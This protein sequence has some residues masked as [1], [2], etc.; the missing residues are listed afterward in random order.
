MN[1][2]II[3]I[4]NFNAQ[5]EQARKKLAQE[6]TAALSYL[7]TNKIRGKFVIEHQIGRMTPRSFP[8]SYDRSLFKIYTYEDGQLSMIEYLGY[9]HLNER[10]R[11]KGAK[12]REIKPEEVPFAELPLEQL[13]NVATQIKGIEDSSH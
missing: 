8:P 2:R 11:I 3:N 10:N 9:R 7:S 1:E 5:I 6:C 13:M 4:G 12:P